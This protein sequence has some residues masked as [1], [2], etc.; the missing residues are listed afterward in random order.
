MHF[1]K[2]WEKVVLKKRLVREFPERKGGPG[3]QGLKPRCDSLCFLLL[4][5][6]GK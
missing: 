6:S 4:W 1:N 2:I 3:P 5:F